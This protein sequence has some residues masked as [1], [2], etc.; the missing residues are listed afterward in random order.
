MIGG[1]YRAILLL[2]LQNGSRDFHLGFIRWVQMYGALV[3]GE[4]PWLEG[5]PTWFPA[6]SKLIS[7]K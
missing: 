5:K 3:E 6:F 7:K 2:I 1:I 4:Y